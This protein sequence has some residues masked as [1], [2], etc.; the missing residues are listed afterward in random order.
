MHLICRLLG[1]PIGDGAVAALLH[2]PAPFP[3]PGS[4]LRPPPLPVPP[5]RT[6]V[7]TQT[8]VPPGRVDCSTA[9][10][11]SVP[12]WFNPSFD[13][14]Y[15]KGAKVADEPRP[16]DS[17]PF[18][19]HPRPPPLAQPP[20]PPAPAPKF[21]LTDAVMRLRAPKPPEPPEPP[22]P[23]EKVEKGRSSLGF[24]FTVDFARSPQPP[25]TTS[26][27]RRPRNRN[28][29]PS[30]RLGG[31]CMSIW[32]PGGRCCSFV[33]WKRRSCQG[34][35]RPNEKR[36]SP[37]ARSRIPSSAGFALSLVNKPFQSAFQ[38]DDNK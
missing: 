3:E 22:V 34:H 18:D 32:K 15:A 29:S 12:V 11:I 8:G 5:D 19:P 2:S 23:T 37:R 31:S 10:R 16:S 20:P 26:A 13:A 17:E 9:T 35:P 14:E 30:G 27:L 25:S 24:H 7:A 1:R 6:D 36:T 38:M 21:A 28:R 33:R 4:R